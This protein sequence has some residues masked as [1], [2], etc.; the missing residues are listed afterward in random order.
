[1]S[2]HGCSHIWYDVRYK[3]SLGLGMRVSVA[4]YVMPRDPNRITP[5]RHME[6]GQTYECGRCRETMRAIVPTRKP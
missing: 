5:P 3:H 6:Y 4:P 2:V 1:M